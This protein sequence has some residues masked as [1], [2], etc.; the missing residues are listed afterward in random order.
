MT[1]FMTMRLQS[2]SETKR[3]ITITHIARL[4][5]STSTTSRWMT[6]TRPTWLITKVTALSTSTSQSITRT[7]RL[8]TR[9]SSAQQIWIRPQRLPLAMTGSTSRGSQTTLWAKAQ[10]S[11]STNALSTPR[12][13]PT[14]RDQ[15]TLEATQL[16]A[17]AS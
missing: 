1:A 9:D 5:T 4:S 12:S 14:T 15:S 7:A 8:T 11:Y 3:Q 13:F 17:P 16:S 10:I 6:T 2:G